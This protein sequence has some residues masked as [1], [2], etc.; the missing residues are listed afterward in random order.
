[1]SANELIPQMTP[2]SVASDLLA[3]IKDIENCVDGAKNEVSSIESRG[4][5]KSVFSSTQTDLVSISRSQNKIN[6]MMLGLIQEVISLNVMSY[7]F[8]VA[9]IGELEQRARDGWVNAEGQFQSLSTTGQDFADKAR[10]IFLRIVEGAKNTQERIE[11]NSAYIVEIRQTLSQE[12]ERVEAMAERLD[13][14][15][16]RDEQQTQTIQALMRDLNENRRVD[17]ERAQAVSRMELDLTAV[18]SQLADL[19]R[20]SD[21]RHKGMK[22]VLYVLAASSALLAAILTFSVVRVM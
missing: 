1:M 2:A 18:R 14:Q 12:T 10:N 22:A 3:V 13:Q 21:A 7:S 6:D 17:D 16:L 11:L 4:W 8:L 15:A 5:F 19:E 9:V 20:R